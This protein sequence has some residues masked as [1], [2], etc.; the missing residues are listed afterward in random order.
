MASFSGALSSHLMEEREFDAAYVNTRHC[1]E[2]CFDSSSGTGPGLF[3]ANGHK[4]QVT[5]RAADA[6]VVA[7]GGRLIADYGSYRLYDV[8]PSALDRKWGRSRDNYNSILLNAGRLDTSTAPSRRCGKRRNV[9]REASSSGAIRGA[10]SAFVATGIAGR[11][12]QDCQ[13]YS[14]ERLSRVWRFPQYCANPDAG[15]SAP[16][17]QWDGEFLDEYKIHPSA[18]ASKTDQF[19]IQLVADDKVNA[20]TLKLLDGLKLAPSARP[21]RVLDF[22][23][24]IVRTPR[25]RPGFSCGAAGCHFDSAVVSAEEIG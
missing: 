13:L 17:Y 6:Q 23:N 3:G 21:R 15:V 7:A 25:Q 11:W 1:E 20:E 22:L 5:D 16:R 12:R 2:Y 14:A 8:P 19:A 24:V 18:R 9:C 10:D 4:L